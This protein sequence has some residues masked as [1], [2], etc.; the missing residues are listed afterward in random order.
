MGFLKKI[1]D[2]K[3]EG[4]VVNN[5]RKQRFNLVR[6][7]FE[8]M[9]R[10]KGKIKVLDIGGD[11]AYWHNVGWT[12]ERCEFFLLNLDQPPVPPGFMNF[13]A[14]TGNALELPYQPGDFD[15]VF[16]NSV[17]EHMGSKEAQEKFAHQVRRIAS[18]FIIQT[19]SFW[20]PLEPHARIPFFQFIP[21]AIRALLIMGFTINYFPRARKYAEAVAVSKTTIMFGKRRFQQLFPDASII[22]ETWMGL[23]KSYIA[24]KEDQAS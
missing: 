11:F 23:P 19:P 2:Y 10:K 14:V 3:T 21:H 16:S 1:F 9:I 8:E 20:F 12:D 17:I 13:H 15:I 24:V 5:I 22:V 18:C 4:S 7:I 6:G